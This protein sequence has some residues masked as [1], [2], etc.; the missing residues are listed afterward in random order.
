MKVDLNEQQQKFLEE[1][2]AIKVE[3]IEKMNLEDWKKVRED[4]FEIETDE[5]L[6][7]EEAGG[8]CDDCETK[9]YLMASSI[10][11]LPYAI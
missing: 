7:Y 3:D 5:L 8:N 4:C 11:D 2:F 10:I 1:K 6:D 9:D